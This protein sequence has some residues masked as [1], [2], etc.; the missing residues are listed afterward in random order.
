MSF[1]IM[2]LVT[3]FLLGLVTVY[4]FDWLIDCLTTPHLTAVYCHNVGYLS[5]PFIIQTSVTYLTPETDVILDHGASDRLRA[6]AGDC[7][8][9]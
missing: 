2:A 6:R 9:Y 1:S 4:S 8:I 5:C 7:L 3:D